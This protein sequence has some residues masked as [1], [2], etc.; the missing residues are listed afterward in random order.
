MNSIKSNLFI[1]GASKSGTTSLH[2]YLDQHPDIYMSQIKETNYFATDL[3]EI[4]GKEAI[5]VLLHEEDLLNYFKGNQKKIK[6]AIIKSATFYEKLLFP[7]KEK[8]IRGESSVSYLL[9]KK[10]AK[11]IYKYNKDVKI[12]IILRNPYKRAFSQYIMELRLG[13]LPPNTT[14]IQAIEEFGRSQYIEIGQYFEQ[15]RRYLGTFPKKNVLIIRFSTFKKEIKNT[16]KD[17]FQ[18]LNVDTSFYVNPTIHNPAKL[19]KYNF[20]NY[21]ISKNKF[22]EKLR[23]RLGYYIP[24]RIKGALTK[25]LYKN[26]NLKIKEKE[27]KYL[28]P[29]FEKNISKLENLLE[30]D[31][32]DLRAK[33]IIGN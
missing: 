32:S 3:K 20:I 25:I 24:E 22:L 23:Y 15:V 17:T 28:I 10:A 14:F 6:T 21:F 13:T 30:E 9:S 5:D 19:P 2:E 1:V 4:W 12:I 8:K 7:G 11:N 18:F 31:Y 26:S 33:K 16:L 29:Y 27:V